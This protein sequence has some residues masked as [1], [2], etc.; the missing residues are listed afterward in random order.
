MDESSINGDR[1]E[2]GATKRADGDFEMWATERVGEGKRKE[3]RVNKYLKHILT[4]VV[5]FLFVLVLNFALPRMLPGDP[6]AY[7]TGFEEEEM[8]EET[9]EFY[10]EALHLDES[11]AEQFGHYLRSVFDGTLG[12]SYKQ[13]SAVAPL[14]LERLGYTLQIM[15]PAA[16]IS[17]A[18]GL[19]WGLSA[20]RRK[21]SLF[22]KLST[23]AL[24][25]WNAVP[26]F[27]VAFTA[28]ILLCIEA[29]AFPYAGLNDP[30]LTPGTAEYFADRLRH[31]FLPVLV[32]VLAALPS[33]YL[34]VRNAAAAY[35]DSKS[36][37]YAS[38]RGLSAAKTEYGYMLGNIAPPVIA[39]AG[40]AVGGCIGGSVVI[41]SVF[42][43]GGVGEL[44]NTA[45]YTLD[46][47]LMQGILFVTALGMIVSIVLSD[48]ACILVDPKVRR[49]GSV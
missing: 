15:L 16:V 14:I 36:V 17:V 20:G 12:Y 49:G 39:M 7:L 24:V 46:Y 45:V 3:A 26:A 18:I 2:T 28:V 42:S 8:T 29:G 34:L 35:A 1:S 21:N 13:E 27:S 43:I 19:V 33:R 41:E 4:A 37:F 9:Y 47:P 22:D 23:S 31:L 44:L 30:G 11:A 10:R 40:T 25:V 38:A 32:A 6:V 48:I 5:C